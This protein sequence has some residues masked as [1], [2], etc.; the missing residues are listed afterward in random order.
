MKKPANSQP[1]FGE[2]GAG[3]TFLNTGNGISVR[4]DTPPQANLHPFRVRL[5]GRQGADFKFSVTPGTINGLVPEVYDSADLMTK[6]PRP[7]GIWD[8]GAG[9]F[10]WLYLKIGNTGSPSYIFPDPTPANAGF[11]MVKAYNAQ[12]TS[13][14]A[15]GFILLAAAH[16]DPATNKV[17]LFQFVTGSLWGDRVKVGNSVAQY[18]FARV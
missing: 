3:C 1:V 16:K 7:L 2:S 4:V 15:E 6:L 5:A 11:P 14:D 12:Q 13:T 18:F 8:F 17:T 10:S 9:D